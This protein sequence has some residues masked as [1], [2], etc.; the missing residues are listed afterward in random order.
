MQPWT[1]LLPPI[2]WRITPRW[3]RGGRLVWRT[4]ITLFCGAVPICQSATRADERDLFATGVRTLLATRCLE[5]H[6]G[7]Q[8]EGGLD[9]SER[10]TMLAG[11]ES[12]AA[13]IAGKADASLLW[14]RVTDDEMPP[15]HPLSVDE[16][17][18]LHAWLV[19]GARWSGD[20]KIDYLQFSSDRRAGLDWWSLQPLRKVAVPP[21]VDTQ[22]PRRDLDR[23]ILAR[24]EAAG[25]A[26]SPEADARTLIRRLAIDLTG[27]PPTPEQ[28]ARF[29][30]DPSDAAYEALVDRLLDAPEYGQRWGRHWLDVVRFGESDGFERNNPR[31]QAWPYRDWVIDAFNADMPY[32]DF[33]RQQLAGDLLT[34][35]PAGAASTGFLVAG[36]HNTVVGS[37]ERMK[38]LARQDE[39]EEIVA[40]VGQAFLGLT[41]NCARCH[42]HK[43][44]P[45]PSEE[46]YRMISALDGVRHGEREVMQPEASAKLAELRQRSEQLGAAIAMLDATARDAILAE[47]GQADSADVPDRPVPLAC[48]EFDGDLRDSRG[49]LHGTAFGGARLEQG[50][51]VVDGVDSFVQTAPLKQDLAAKTLEAWV[52]LDNLDQRGGAAISV[53]TP[54][55]GV[56]DAIVFGEREPR[57]W[58]AGSNSFVRTKSFQARGEDQATDQPVHVAIVYQ[59][60]GTVTGYRNGVR[61]G[62]PYQTSHAS[63]AAGNAQVVFGLRHHPPGG[64][65]LLA[66][67]ILRANLYDDALSAEAVAASAGR[68]NN[69][70]SPAA[71]MKWL[72]TEART[73]RQRMS[74]ELTQLEAQIRE[75]DKAARKTIYTV[76]PGN[77]SRMRVHLRGSV[78]DLGP[79]VEPG[80]IA[81]VTGAN[82]SF[83]LPADASDAERRQKLAA[84]ITANT[85]PLLPRVIVNRIWHYHFGIGLVDTPNDLGFNGG[86]PSH[87]NLI[88]WLAVGFRDGGYLLKPLHRQI[89]TSATYRQAST[90]NAA[91]ITKDANNRLLW[92]YS[93]R[94]I[95]AEVLRDA[96]LHVSGQLNRQ[97]GGPGFEDVSSTLNNGTTYYEPIDA[98]GAAFHRRTVYRFSPRGGRSALLDTFDC[99]D[100]SSAAPRRSV[101]T[102]PLQALSLLNNSFAL[103]MS[104]QFAARVEQE[105]GADL[106][107]QVRQAWQYA[108]ARYPDETEQQASLKLVQQYGLPMLARALFNTNEFVVIE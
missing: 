20:A 48:W 4:M 56:F 87:P 52:L 19:A 9:L 40:T 60:D 70:V 81:A 84:W 42:D 49:D 55:G 103:R 85:N 15:K 32:D 101:T 30:A 90:P 75:V 65:R 59:A 35:G 28:V 83:E 24:L 18:L 67:R 104:E 36:V 82:A 68:E 58:M 13:I 22:W 31:K 17:E 7:P 12:G 54:D 62:Q 97:A 106:A 105:A 34:G 57:R 94:R 44:D 61:C 76:S 11:G 98:S 96:M 41:V 77:P 51:L 43:F 72:S 2:Q 47:R 33:V 69:Y 91:A 93:P 1:S 92:R 95:E 6:R 25:L 21:V 5:C 99:P 27:L 37:S 80:G 8:P 3:P 38:L 88:D 100:P 14:Q 29:V 74:Q 10:A 45:I 46:Y 71:I 79:E 78:T 89:V 64:N 16:K 53:E 63:F 108:I 26:P 102:T 50:A 66:G 73:Q 23:F 86:R 39:L 107:A